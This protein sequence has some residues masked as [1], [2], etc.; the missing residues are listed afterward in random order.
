MI[1]DKLNEQE[2]RHRSEIKELEKTSNDALHSMARGWAEEK[3]RNGG[4]SS[5]TSLHGN[6]LLGNMV[7]QGPQV[8]L[9]IWKAA[10]KVSLFLFH[11]VFAKL[12]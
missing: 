10:M 9:F 8:E 4:G 6:R 11:C 3:G 1:D 5:T 2:F 7:G 12:L